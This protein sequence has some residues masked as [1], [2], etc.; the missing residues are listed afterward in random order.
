MTGE[1]QTNQACTR[2]ACATSTAIA[3]FTAAAAFALDRLTKSWALSNLQLHNSQPFIE[4]FLR[5]TLTTNTGAAFSLG[6][7]NATFMTITAVVLTLALTV[8]LGSRIARGHAIPV[9]ELIGLSCIIGGSLGNL[10]DRFSQGHVTDFLEFA[11]FS[12]PVFNVADTFIN[13]GLG[14]VLIGRIGKGEESD[15]PDQGKIEEKTGD[16]K[17]T[18]S[19]DAL[20]A[21]PEKS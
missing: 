19:K 1:D 10:T 13:I 7:N 2:K 20:P 18:D 5:L 16:P 12:F 8:W 15:T 6:A 17:D 3:L 14:L 9:I 11:F 4:G 21:S